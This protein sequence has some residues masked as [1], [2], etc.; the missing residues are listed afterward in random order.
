MNWVLLETPKSTDNFW[1]WVLVLFIAFPGL[2]VFFGWIAVIA[3]VIASPF[4]AGFVWG[5]LRALLVPEAPVRREPPLTR[6][7]V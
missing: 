5:V 3:L 7:R 6:P 2:A 4:I 1:L